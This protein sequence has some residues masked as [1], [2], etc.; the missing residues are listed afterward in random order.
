MTRQELFTWYIP[1]CSPL[2]PLL[3]F[4]P[5]STYLEPSFCDRIRPPRSQVARKQT[6]L[7]PHLAHIPSHPKLA[8]TPF[9]IPLILSYFIPWYYLRC[10]ILS[11]FE[12]KLS[13][14]KA[15]LF[16]LEAK[17]RGLFL[18]FPSK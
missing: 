11:T 9:S 4:A 13:K 8:N 12:T 7:F 14:L 6:P 10:T 15:K 2:L 17:Q 3:P 1:F 18:R 16:S 5:F